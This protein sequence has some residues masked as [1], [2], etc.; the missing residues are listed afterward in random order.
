MGPV[1]TALVWVVVAAHFAFLIYLLLGGFLALR[2]RR[3]IW[4]HLLVVLWAIG[5]VTVHLD[6]PLTAVERWAR[7]CAGLPPLPAG[8]FIDHY[9]T[10]V[11]Y[12]AENTGVAQVA[13]FTAVVA[14]WVA[15]GLAR[16]GGSRFR[17]R[18]DRR[19]KFP[20]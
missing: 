2:W 16:R 5:S 13:V 11:L 3:T 6:C 9:V 12:P 18:V 14:S 8:G 10:G 15:Y 7:R 20:E 17:P 19:N 1:C 4:L